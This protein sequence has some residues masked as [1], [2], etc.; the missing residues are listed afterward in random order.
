M[1]SYTLDDNQIN[2][3]SDFNGTMNK[4]EP[5]DEDQDFHD[6]ETTSETAAIYKDDDGSI[7]N[8]NIDDVDKEV[9]DSKP[10]LGSLN[11]IAGNADD[12]KANE[13]VN[14]DKKRIDNDVIANDTNLNET[15]AND[16]DGGD[17]KLGIFSLFTFCFF[18]ESDYIFIL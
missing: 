13:N 3:K 8:G 17:S 10:N 2:A 9:I 6:A 16:R 5:I 18:F 1:H 7:D 11:N 15:E 4:I 12:D 14:L